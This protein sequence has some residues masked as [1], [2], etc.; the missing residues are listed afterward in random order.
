[1]QRCSLS[2]LLW[3]PH[4]NANVLSFSGRNSPSGSRL[5]DSAHRF[6]RRAIPPRKTPKYVVGGL[7]LLVAVQCAVA[8]ESRAQNLVRLSEAPSCPRCRVSVR[9]I[10]TLSLPGDSIRFFVVLH[11]GRNS[12]GEYVVG[13]T[14]DVSRF[15]VFNAS[16]KLV[17]VVGRRGTAP[18]EGSVHT[19]V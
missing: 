11:I 5:A 9:P 1:M 17:R 10:T 8:G 2:R 4:R 6:L 19:F 7:V 16:G 12:R 15:V 13:P 18:D 14:A 3:R